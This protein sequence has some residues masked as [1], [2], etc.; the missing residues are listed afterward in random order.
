MLAEGM[1]ALSFASTRV[2][3]MPVPFHVMVSNVPGPLEPIALHGAPL[4]SL[5]GLGPIRHSMGLFHVVSNSAEYFTIS[6]TS[7]RSIMPDAEFYEQCLQ[8]SFWELLA[9]SSQI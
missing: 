8:E 4:H 9:A 3:E 2:S 5:I 7:C 6:F 1:R